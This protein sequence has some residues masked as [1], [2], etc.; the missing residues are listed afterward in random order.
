MIQYSLDSNVLIT[1]WNE[2]YSLEICPPY[3]TYL[4]MLAQRGVI[5]CSEIVFEEI[6][7]K[8][9]ELSKWIRSVQSDFVR[10]SRSEEIQR[11]VADITNYIGENNIYQNKGKKKWALEADIW[12]VAHA[13][14]ENATVVTNENLID[15]NSSKIKKIPNLCKKYNLQCINDRQMLRDLHIQFALSEK[16]MKEVHEH[17]KGK[18]TRP[19]LDDFIK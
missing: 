2:Y 13:C 5:F 8:D 6:T 15:E 1:A 14:V 3:W 9:D 19:S 17:L 16:N 12:V 7:N 4:H 11:F 18:T 10:E